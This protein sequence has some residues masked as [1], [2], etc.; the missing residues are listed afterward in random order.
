MFFKTKLE[1]RLISGEM[2]SKCSFALIWSAPFELTLNADSLKVI[3]MAE[4]K[5]N[6]CPYV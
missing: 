4:M 1:F 3:G 2:V 6:D 5:L